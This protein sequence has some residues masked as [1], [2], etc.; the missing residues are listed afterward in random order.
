[1]ISFLA[2]LAL[3]PPGFRFGGGGD[4][5]LLKA[6]QT[7][8]RTK[9]PLIALAYP[10]P[11][12][13]F[14]F[15]TDDRFWARV[16]SESRRQIEGDLAIGLALHRGDYPPPAFGGQGQTVEVGPLDARPFVASGKVVGKPEEPFRTGDLSRARWSKNLR[17]HYV[18]RD[19]PIVTVPQNA[20]ERTFLKTLASTVGAK[21]GDGDAY[22]LKF[23]PKEFRVRMVPTIER[24]RKRL[25]NLGRQRDARAWRYGVLREAMTAFSDEEL[26]TAFAS[27]TGRAQ[28]S[29]RTDRLTKSIKDYIEALHDLSLLSSTRPVEK[30]RAEMVQDA[31]LSKPVNVTVF[32]DMGLLIALPR[33]GGGTIAL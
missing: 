14:S 32:G 21:F 13:A 23:D 25:L 1:M 24:W 5:S 33:R 4:F 27:P 17:I 26:T 18:Y 22:D 31:D 30:R 29:R 11:I 16:Q 8:E 7:D 20:S 12:A 15:T 28:V 6:L 2:A 9:G 10:E 3:V 19:V